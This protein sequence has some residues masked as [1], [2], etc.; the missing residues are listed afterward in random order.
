MSVSPTSPKNSHTLSHP[1]ETEDHTISLHSIN[2]DSQDKDSAFTS[3]RR[4]SYRGRLVR[5]LWRCLWWSL[6]LGSTALCPQLQRHFIL[7]AFLLW[8]LI[9][10]HM[11]HADD[12]TQQL[13]SNSREM[14]TRG[15]NGPSAYAP[16]TSS[17][18]SQLHWWSSLQDECTVLSIIHDAAV[19]QCPHG[20]LKRV[21]P[22]FSG[23]C[24]WLSTSI[25]SHLGFL[26]RLPRP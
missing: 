19:C 3:I 22:W 23:E 21:V 12:A 15:E 17:S 1:D 10:W 20:V 9:V 25:F 14:C 24:Q 2:T 16:I 7:V 5:Q 18:R 6:H 26:S 4:G 13:E 11:I 8:L